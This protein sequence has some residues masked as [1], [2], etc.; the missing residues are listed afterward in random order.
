MGITEKT[1]QML[2]RMIVGSW[3]TQAIYVASAIP[4]S[5]AT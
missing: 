1:E 3:V 2:S 5:D 4:I